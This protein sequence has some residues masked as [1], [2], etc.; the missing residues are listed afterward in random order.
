MRPTLEIDNGARYARA[1]FYD[2]IAAAGKL[3]DIVSGPE[4]LGLPVE[5]IMNLA[6]VPDVIT[7]RED[8][9]AEVEKLFRDERRYA[10]TAGGVFGVCNCEVDVLSRDDVVQTLGDNSPAG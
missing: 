9:K 7:R 3:I 5:V 2:H 6:L 1:G 8:V 4:Q 10:E